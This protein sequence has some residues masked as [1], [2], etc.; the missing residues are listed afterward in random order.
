MKSILVFCGSKAGVHPAYAEAASLAGRLMA[1]KQVRMVY[2]GGGVGLMGVS[3][4]SALEYGGDVVGIIPDFLQHI[5]GINMEIAELHIV[6]SMHVRKQKMA[7]LSD[8]VMVLPGGFGT[9]DEL[10]EMLTLIQLKQGNWPVGILNVNGYYDH[11]VAHINHMREAGFI[12]TESQN[13][14]TVFDDVEKMIDYLIAQPVYPKEH[15]ERL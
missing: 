10:F 1:E 15:L 2:G 11:L 5:E 12:S 8:A 13:L 9:L 7:E 4:R 6:D 3:A 14:T